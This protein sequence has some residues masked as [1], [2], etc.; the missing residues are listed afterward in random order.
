MCEGNS[1]QIR[2]HVKR[3]APLSILLYS[4]ARASITSCT[5]AFM[6]GALA[7]P[8]ND[9]APALTYRRCMCS[10]AE[11]PQMT[12]DDGYCQPERGPAQVCDPMPPSETQNAQAEPGVKP[13][14]QSLAE[15]RAEAVYSAMERS[16]RSCPTK[17]IPA[18]NCQRAAALGI[19]ASKLLPT[20]PSDKGT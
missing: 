19:A 14:G 17:R 10:G 8:V 20:S 5:S 15:K 13:Q 12:D 11:E 9:P 2:V 18:R 1:R 16:A 6:C 3:P 7:M 4:L